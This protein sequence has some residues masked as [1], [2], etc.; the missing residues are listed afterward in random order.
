MRYYLQVWI[1]SRISKVTG[2]ITYRY[3]N[4]NGFCRL[5]IT[6]LVDLQNA[7]DLT[8]SKSV[9]FIEKCTPI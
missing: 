3:T 4:N 2:N 8:G 9:Y 5:I 6:L 1:T 7:C